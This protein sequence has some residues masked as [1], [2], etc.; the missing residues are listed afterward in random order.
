MMAASLGVSWMAGSLQEVLNVPGI[1]S[2]A[3]TIFALQAAWIL[4]SFPES[5]RDMLMKS[6]SGI[7]KHSFLY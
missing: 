4:R 6:S 3:V 1:S 2:A 5:P 7:R